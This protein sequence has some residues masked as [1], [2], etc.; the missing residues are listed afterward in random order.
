MPVPQGLTLRFNKLNS[1][2]ALLSFL[3]GFFA[4]SILEGGTNQEAGVREF[5]DLKGKIFSYFA[6]PYEPFCQENLSVFRRLL[7]ELK[8]TADGGM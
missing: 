1:N 7:N 5:H 8:P 2:D 3:D 6:K 4:V